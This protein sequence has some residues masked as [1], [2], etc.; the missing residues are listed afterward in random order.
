MRE[1]DKSPKDNNQ[2]IS[3]EGQRGLLSS[4]KVSNRCPSLG[5]N[6]QFI[7]EDDALKYLAGILVEIFLDEELNEHRTNQSQSKESSN[8]LQSINQRAG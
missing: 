3:K 1:L 8:I 6:N 2:I 5:F 7:S 4:N